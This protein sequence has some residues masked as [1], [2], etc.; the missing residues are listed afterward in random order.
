MKG[1]IFTRWSFTGGG[2]QSAVRDNMIQAILHFLKPVY[3]GLLRIVMKGVA[4]IRA[5]GAKQLAPTSVKQKL[6]E[7]WQS[8]TNLADMMKCL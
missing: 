8:W 5:G 4:V 7:I 6:S 1:S 3:Q 2:G